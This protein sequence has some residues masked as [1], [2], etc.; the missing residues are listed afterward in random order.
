[1]AEQLVGTWDLESSE[2]WEEYMKEI[3]VGMIQRK[4]AAAIKPTI[5][6][7]NNAKHWTF[8]TKTTLKNTEFEATEDQEFNESKNFSHAAILKA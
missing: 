8:K 4:A 1:M 7:T 2:K 3:G 6:I 5:Y